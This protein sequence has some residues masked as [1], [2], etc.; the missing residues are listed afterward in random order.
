M[1][2]FLFLIIAFIIFVPILFFLPLGFQRSGQYLI[3]F[4]S[5]IF[6][7]L[8]LFMMTMFPLWKVVL[9]LVL[10]ILSSL[11]LVDR[12]MGHLIY[13]T[14]DGFVDENRFSSLENIVGR[15]QD[16]NIFQTSDTETLLEEGEKQS[17][18]GEKTIKESDFISYIDEKDEKNDNETIEQFS[19]VQ[20]ETESNN[21]EQTIQ[22][23]EQESDDDVEEDVSFLERRIQLLDSG[24]TISE[25]ERKTH[26]LSGDETD[27]LLEIEQIDLSHF[28]EEDGENLSN[29]ND[30]FIEEIYLAPLDE[31]TEAKEE[32]LPVLFDDVIPELQFEDIEGQVLKER[33]LEDEPSKHCQ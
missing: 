14:E 5:F 16:N 6:A 19:V 2:A 23:T 3:V 11:Y 18:F 13:E 1:N 31:G 8:G 17:I 21:N 4:S 33:N 12:K 32:E 30:D 28:I 27:M 26:G 29:I 20:I 9:L 7:L 22:F 24:E 25:Y 15:N 10:L